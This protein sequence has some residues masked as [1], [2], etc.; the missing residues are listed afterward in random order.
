MRTAVLVLLCLASAVLGSADQA[1]FLRV[2]LNKR[3]LQ[4]EDIQNAKA[5]VQSRYARMRLNA[6]R[7]EPE[8]AD[9]PLLDFLDAQC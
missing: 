8:E 7:G 6:L 5:A 2:P 1:T 9:I 3:Q 4:L